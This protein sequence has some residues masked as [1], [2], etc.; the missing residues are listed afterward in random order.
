MLSKQIALL[1]QQLG[2]LKLKLETG[3]QEQE[4]LTS[5]L[6]E[7]RKEVDQLRMEKASVEKQ[8]S[9]QETQPAQPEDQSVEEID[10]LKKKAA[11]LAKLRRLCDTKKDGRCKV[12]TEIQA[13]WKAGGSQRSHLLKVFAENG[14]DKD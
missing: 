3:K 9:E 5:Q 1:T 4:N 13:M 8:L 6:A 12:S 2:D 11:D 10:E 7:S 14:Y